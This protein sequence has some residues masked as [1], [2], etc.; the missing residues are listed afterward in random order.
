MKI[1]IITATYNSSATIKDT[2]ESIRQQHYPD[3]EHLIIDGLSKDDT[4]QIVK[5]YPHISQCISEKD[6]GIYDAMN[7]G[8]GLSTG[9]VI[10]ILNSDDFYA[11]N[12]VIDKVAR[13]F[14]ETGCDAL[15]GDLQYVDAEN[16]GKIIRYWK[17]GD[18]QP[19]AFKWGWMPPHPT[20][21]VRRELYQQ[22]G[23][24]NLHMK[25]AA[26]YELMLRFI[27]KHGAKIA[28]LPEV[29][30]KMRTGGASNSSLSSRL[31]ANQEDKQAWA[32]NGLHPFWFTLYLKPIRKITQYLIK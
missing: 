11:N 18:Y 2:L 32:I 29:L 3:I 24:F 4:L 7:K 13:V 22:F 12:Q 30:V 9:D 6:K 15:Y 25:T 27:H 19:G 14:T 21:F 26:D 20:F 5:A 16:T 28:Y 23:N 8:I 1:S 31:R 10:G 17:S